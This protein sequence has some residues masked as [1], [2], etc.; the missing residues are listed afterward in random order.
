MGLVGPN[1]LETGAS[2][3]LFLL[4]EEAEAE[5]AAFYRGN[6]CDT[7]DGALKGSDDYADGVAENH[8]HDDEVSVGSDGTMGVDDLHRALRATDD[9][10]R[11]NDGFVDDECNATGRYL[12]SRFVSWDAWEDGCSSNG[13]D[14]YG[15]D[16]IGAYEDDDKCDDFYGLNYPSDGDDMC[17]DFGKY[18]ERGNLYESEGHED[19]VGAYKDNDDYDAYDDNAYDND[20]VDDGYFDD[21]NG[22]G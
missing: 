10:W 19:V 5:E 21:N 16:S 11:C 13:A 4:T 6:A 14:A 2:V 20:M 1:D 15:D 7:A 9:H 12:N 3:D 17:G 22:Y 8:W 18:D